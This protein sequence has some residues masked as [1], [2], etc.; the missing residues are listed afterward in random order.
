MQLSRRSGALLLIVALALLVAALAGPARRAWDER[1]RAQNARALA[2]K[3]AQERAAAKERFTA[4]R[5]QILAELRARIE[6]KD[7]AAAMAMA[8]PYVPVGDDELRALHRQAAGAESLRQRREAYRALVTRDCT[9]ANARRHATTIVAAASDRFA[10]AAPP[11]VAARVTGTQAHDA[12]LSRL[13]EPPSPHLDPNAP[14]HVDEPSHERIER[15]KHEYRARI[16]PDYQGF[17]L[18]GGADDLICAWHLEGA[19]KA[20]SSTLRY[21]IDLWLAPHPDGKSLAPDLLAFSDRPV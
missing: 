14:E 10:A 4:D 5:T 9:E 3:V 2:E 16:L 7:Y 8:S 13:R 6:R 17:L 11:L 15:L 12:I 21:A 1:T 19:R 20:G 18:A